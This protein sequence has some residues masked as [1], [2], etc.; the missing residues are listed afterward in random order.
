MADASIRRMF[1]GTLAIVIEERQPIGIGRIKGRLFLID[2]TGAVVDEF[3]PNYADLD[4]PIVDGL[5]R[6]RE[7]E[8]V[9]ERRAARPAV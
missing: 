3:G 7:N 6:R 9:D 8:S 5:M 4:L 2:E 1:P